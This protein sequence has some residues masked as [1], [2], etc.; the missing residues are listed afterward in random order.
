MVPHLVSDV[1]PPGFSHGFTTRAGGVSAAPFDSL[2]LGRRW[3]DADHAVSEN[4]RRLCEAAGADA[5]HFVSQV[6]GTRVIR[7]RSGDEATLQPRPEADGTATDLRGAG[8]AVFVA[9]CVPVLLADERTGAC[10]AV[11]AGWRGVVGGIGA[12]A[13]AVMGREWGSRVGDIKVA[14]GPCIG[15]CCF[16]VGDEVVAAFEQTIPGL[17]A[18]DGIKDVQG[19]PHIDLR[20]AL[21]LLF[22]NLGLSVSSIDQS[23]ACTRCD[24][25]QRFYSYRRDDRRTGQ[26]VGFIMRRSGSP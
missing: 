8:L 9:D 2:N 23:D 24:P 18:V 11:H 6:H 16:Q 7:I 10:A 5:I 17:R 20:R 4:R 1:I 14:M 19:R 21:R 22:E 25:E 12:E 15:V 3:G 13:V 26:Q